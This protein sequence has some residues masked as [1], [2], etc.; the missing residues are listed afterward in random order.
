MPKIKVM[1]PIV[2]MDGDEMT[3]IIWSMIKE[4][5]IFPF[6]EV[7]LKYYDLDVQKRDETDDEITTAV[8][9]MGSSRKTL[10]PLWIPS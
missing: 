7:N 2:E 1:T 6:L 3:R 5:L 10:C 4:K 8:L 9:R